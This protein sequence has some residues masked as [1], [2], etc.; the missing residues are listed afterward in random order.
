MKK[1]L[2]WVLV[3][4]GVALG[5]YVLIFGFG[6]RAAYETE[7][8][9]DI[10]Y[11][12]ST[13][14]RLVRL[15]IGD[16]AFAIPQ[17]HIWSRESWKGG[18]F[19]GVNL[20]ALLPTLEPYTESNRKEFEKLGWNRK[21][22]LS[23]NA[24]NMPEMP[25]T[26]ASMSRMEVYKRMMKSVDQQTPREVSDK[27]GPFGLTYRMWTKPSPGDGQLYVGKKNDGSFYWVLCIGKGRDKSPS[28]Q[29]Y[30]DYSK[31]VAIH[32]IF[33][34][35]LLSDWETIDNAIPNFVHRL[36]INSQ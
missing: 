14:D 11:G 18:R 7:K 25:T 33:S 21:I 16:K 17:N 8:R 35:D 12:T 32:Y 13:S 20:H 1:A 29:T 10:G 22:V 28:C 27:E 2:K 23:I 26:R 6:I 34:I 30:V 5:F 36:E 3:F 4:I 19:D 31:H 9:L 15:E 24:H